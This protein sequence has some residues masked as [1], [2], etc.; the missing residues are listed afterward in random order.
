MLPLVLAVA[1]TL[2]RP[3]LGP[4]QTSLGS[5]A[6]NGTVTVWA[7]LRTEPLLS[8]HEGSATQGHARLD[9]TREGLGHGKEN[10][11]KK[12]TKKGRAI[13]L[14]RPEALA[15]GGG[16]GL[17]GAWSSVGQR[18]RWVKQED[19]SAAQCK[20]LLAWVFGRPEEPTKNPR[21]SS[22]NGSPVAPAH[23][24]G[25]PSGSPRSLPR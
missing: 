15:A 22:S 9:P 24:P 25:F 2:Q 8:T 5:R 6:A 20:K 11:K 14:Y 1:A 3:L 21:G 10:K 7:A 4:P 16:R 18:A 23:R 17:R 19:G 13:F 12:E